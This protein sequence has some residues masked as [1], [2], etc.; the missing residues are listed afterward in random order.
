MCDKFAH[1]RAAIDALTDMQDGVLHASAKVMCIDL[2]TALLAETV[3]VPLNGGLIVRSDGG[4]TPFGVNIIIES[5]ILL[6]VV[7]VI[8]LEDVMP[9]SYA[10]DV[11][12]G[13]VID[14]LAFTFIDVVNG[15]GVDVSIDAGANMWRATMFAGLM[16]A[17]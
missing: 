3:I 11:R 4:M 16:M 1:S 8:D 13:V 15:S 17:S 5:R 9:V 6:D 7:A 10:R 2:T 12:A 14:V